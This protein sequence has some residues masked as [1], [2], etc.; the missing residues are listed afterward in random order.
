M[1][2]LMENAIK[3]DDLGGKPTIFGNIRVVE[4]L[5]GVGRCFLLME[6]FLYFFGWDKIIPCEIILDL[7]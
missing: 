1:D 5:G 4:P 7:F 6:M 3:M 2:G